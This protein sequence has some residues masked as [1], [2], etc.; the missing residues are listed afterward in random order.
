MSLSGRGKKNVRTATTTA[1]RTRKGACSFAADVDLLK[2]QRPEQLWFMPS[3]S[4]TDWILALTGTGRAL[5][6]CH[7]ALA[8]DSLPEVWKE[9]QP[10]MCIVLCLT[11]AYQ[12]C[13]TD[14]L[15][16][17]SV[18]MCCVESLLPQLMWC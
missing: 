15:C 14:V 9:R 12:F 5:G 2:H 13:P 18:F 7:A 10:L 11:Q 6:M 4:T 1:Q 3:K 17:L 8:Q 16:L